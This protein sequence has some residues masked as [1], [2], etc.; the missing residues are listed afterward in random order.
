MDL[1]LIDDMKCQS[2]Q[3]IQHN[4]INHGL[5]LLDISEDEET[6]PVTN[7]IIIFTKLSIDTKN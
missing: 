3:I 2:N 6:F 7:Y 4:Y 5:S 1:I